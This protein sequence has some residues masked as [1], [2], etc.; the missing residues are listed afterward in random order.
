MNEFEDDGHEAGPEPT[1]EVSELK[2][3][4]RHIHAVLEDR[5]A[6]SPRID[7]VTPHAVITQLSEL[8]SVHRQIVA[9]EEAFDAEYPDTTADADIDFCA[10]RAEI[11]S[12]LD[13]LRTA[14]LADKVPGEPDP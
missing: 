5:L 14:M 7:A 8:Q 9:A 6:A 1:Y 10:L 11:G 4:F 13:R 3:I 12:Q 2:R